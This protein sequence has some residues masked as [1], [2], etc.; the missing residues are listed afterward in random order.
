MQE[1]VSAGQDALARVHV[2]PGG[3]HGRTPHHF[4]AST[5]ASLMV[6]VLSFHDST[7]HHLHRREW[8]RR[9]YET[10]PPSVDVR[11]VM[12]ADEPVSDA[13]QQDVLLFNVS[14]VHRA[15]I[16]KFL[17]QNAFF[18]HAVALNSHDF[19]ARAD[20]DAVVNVTQVALSLVALQAKLTA[21]AFVIF[22]PFHNFYSW[23]PVSMDASCWS[24][25]LGAYRQAL[26]R[27]RDAKKL[28]N[29]STAEVLRYARTLPAKEVHP[30]LRLEGPYPFAAGPFIAYSRPLARWVLRHL[31][32]SE[33]YVI[34]ERP[35]MEL[36]RP[37]DGLLVQPN[38]TAHPASQVFK[39]EV[40]WAYLIWQGL[41]LKPIYLV[42]APMSE[43]KLVRQPEHLLR[44]AVV[45]HRMV[46]PEHFEHVATSGYL[47]TQWATAFPAN[48][49][50][51]KLGSWLNLSTGCC[52]HWQSCTLQGM[53]A[54]SVG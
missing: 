30:C 19:V 45:F 35:R 4:Q 22:G 52:L 47:A 15:T 3:R 9:L 46:L 23:D 26:A 18:R 51:G 7:G 2:R 28:P 39:E 11:F 34:E 17:L 14:S 24:Y 31:G 44:D 10:S 36:V 38:D 48:C 6:G 16:S 37:V 54:R 42:H 27:F 50:G 33:R 53:K 21:S 5:T 43:Y 29:T 25:G 20:D 12:A 40:Y 41:A 8:L 32:D 13:R 49:D 1:G